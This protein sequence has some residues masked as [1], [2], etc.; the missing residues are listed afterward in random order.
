M[1]Q[2]VGFIG[3]G[4]M[5]SR[6]AANLLKKGERLKVY[7]V[8]PSATEKL[9]GAQP[10]KSPAEAAEDTSLVITMLPNGDTVEETLLGDSGILKSMKRGAFLL[11]SSTIS[12]KTAAKLH[13]S[14]KEREVNFFDAPVSG[15]VTGA[16]AGTLTFMLGADKTQ[17]P[18]DCERVLLKMGKRVVH[19]GKPGS[20]QIAKLCNNAILAATMGVTAEALNLGI[21]MGLDPHLLTSIVNTSTGQSWSSSTYNPVPGIL[22]KVPSSQGYEGGFSCSLVAKDLGLVETTAVDCSVPVPLSAA[23]HQLYRTMIRNGYGNKDFS[24]IYQ[25]LKGR[26]DFSSST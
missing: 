25:F 15:G 14:A 5:G 3:L 24:V 10:C 2:Y 19:C 9:R 21:K 17:I 6:M 1:A 7:D 11:D 22:E 12:P 23:I 20:G 16:E 8:L 26:D 4:N 18:S 13:D